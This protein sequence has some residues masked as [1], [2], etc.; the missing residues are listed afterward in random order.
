MVA[1]MA[2]TVMKGP[3]PTMF[4]ILIV[5]AFRSP[6]FLGRCALTGPFTDVFCTMQINIAD[7]ARARG[8]KL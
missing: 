2:G 6:N 7:F 1:R 4:D 3:V 8:E 5:I